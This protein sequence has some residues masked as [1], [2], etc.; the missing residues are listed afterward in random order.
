MSDDRES[1]PCP[2]PRLA[3]LASIL[4]ITTH[5]SPGA[6]HF[7]AVYRGSMRSLHAHLDREGVAH[8]WSY[9]PPGGFSGDQ[10]IP[11]VQAIEIPGLRIGDGGGMGGMLIEE[12]PE[13]DERPGGLPGEKTVI[14]VTTNG[15][16]QTFDSWRAAVDSIRVDAGELDDVS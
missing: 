16:T 4:K 1:T 5:R 7:H 14:V 11:S 6:T 2:S 15:T 3:L 8:G 10:S 13:W 9:C 12:C